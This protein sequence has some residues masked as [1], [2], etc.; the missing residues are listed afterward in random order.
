LGIRE[1]WFFNNNQFAIYHLPGNT[2]EVVSQSEL[3]RN[4]DLQILAQ[5]YAV[6]NDPLDAA[7]EFW[8]K[9]EEMVG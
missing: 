9:I 6:A 7:L 2:Y 1:V 3:L 5:Y 4:L 8:E